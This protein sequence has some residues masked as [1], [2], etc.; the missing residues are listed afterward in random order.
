MDKKSRSDK[1]Y[2]SRLSNSSCGRQLYSAT[3]SRRSITNLTS[4]NASGAKNN[5]VKVDIRSAF[6][7]SNIANAYEDEL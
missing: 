1:S 3:R 5:A 2:G 6:S 4:P 7:K